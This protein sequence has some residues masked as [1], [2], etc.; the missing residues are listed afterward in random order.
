MEKVV[1][2]VWVSRESFWKK[3]KPKAALPEGWL[4]PNTLHL[5]VHVV[6]SDL[7]DLE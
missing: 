1:S 4:L 7:E 2:Y 3:V 6:G 5:K